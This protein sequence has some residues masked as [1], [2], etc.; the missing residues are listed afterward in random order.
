V[1]RFNGA[2]RDELLNG[3]HFDSPLARVV[4]GRWVDEYNTLR[5]ASR[6]RLQD[7]RSVL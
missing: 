7:A 4:R 2:M 3:E 1:E 6:P 5:A